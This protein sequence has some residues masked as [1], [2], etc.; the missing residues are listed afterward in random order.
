MP[1]RT[2]WALLGAYVFTL[3]AFPLGPFHGTRVKERVY[4]PDWRTG[5]R[6]SFTRDVTA[7]ALSGGKTAI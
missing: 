6:V 2:S 5:E 3:N 1:S 4:E 7:T